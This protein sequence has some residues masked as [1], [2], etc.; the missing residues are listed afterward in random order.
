MSL[1]QQHYDSE[2]GHEIDCR[3]G[4][5]DYLLLP[6]VVVFVVTVFVGIYPPRKQA[7]RRVPFCRRFAALATSNSE[8]P[9]VR[10]PHGYIPLQNVLPLS[11]EQG[12][13]FSID[14]SYLCDNR[15][16]EGRWTTGSLFSA[17]ARVRPSLY[18]LFA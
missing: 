9:R 1:S 6:S 13:V 15:R 8:L 17:S 4:F 12:V 16:G 7:R 14:F 10:G 2:S 11:L 5:R 3:V 18:R